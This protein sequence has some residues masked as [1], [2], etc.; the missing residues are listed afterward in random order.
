[1]LCRHS[2][3]KG[4]IEV[5][6]TYICIF[7]RSSIKDLASILSLFFPRRL[8]SGPVSFTGTVCTCRYPSLV[9]SLRERSR[10]YAADLD[11]ENPRFFNAECK[12][13][14]VVTVR[15]HSVLCRSSVAEL[16]STILTIV[17]SN[18]G[19]SYSI[20][21]LPCSF[22]LNDLNNGAASLFYSQTLL[23]PSFSFNRRCLCRFASL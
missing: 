10:I 4:L 12:S 14:K 16:T 20:C 23:M 22:L 8:F 17:E 13:S 3:E 19:W 5:Q 1:M 7:I 18:S 6:K 21:G 15:R 11:S 9:F 2:R